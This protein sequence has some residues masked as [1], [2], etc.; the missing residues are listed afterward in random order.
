MTRK[1]SSSRQPEALR[2]QPIRS[3]IRRWILVGAPLVSRITRRCRQTHRPVTRAQISVARQLGSSAVRGAQ[4][5][6]HVTQSRTVTGLPPTSRDGSDLFRLEFSVS[7]PAAVGLGAES[8]LVQI[9]SPRLTGGFCPALHSR[10]SAVQSAVCSVV[11][12]RAGFEAD[13]KP[14]AGCGRGRLGC[15]TRPLLSRVCLAM[16]ADRAEARPAP[17]RLLGRSSRKPPQPS[18][19][20]VEPAGQ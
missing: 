16:A 6:V 20:A 13:A 1:I 18:L 4:L 2:A 14:D 7:T 3:R 9:Q 11:Q 17:V 15:G 19:G 5:P 10:A 8:S 12:G